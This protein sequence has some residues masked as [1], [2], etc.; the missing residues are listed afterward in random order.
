VGSSGAAFGVANYS[1]LT[2]LQLLKAANQ[3]AYHGKLWDVN[4]NGGFSTSEL[5]SRDLAYDVF[6]L[7][8]ES[9]TIV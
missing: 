4:G 9:G 2:V 7:I 8:N 3:R 5:T 1:S 6:A